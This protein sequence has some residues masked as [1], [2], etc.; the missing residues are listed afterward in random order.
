MG[1]P[2]EE[3]YKVIPSF[4]GNR[5]SSVSG[6]LIGY[7]GFLDSN[8]SGSAW[9]ISLQVNVDRGLCAIYLN[10]IGEDFKKNGLETG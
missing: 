4:K 5:Y 9:S 2:Y 7:A 1:M 10:F 8:I 6:E 3:F